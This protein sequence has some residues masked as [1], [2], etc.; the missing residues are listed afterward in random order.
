M[1]NNFTLKVSIS[2]FTM[3]A[4]CQIKVLPSERIKNNHSSLLKT[5]SFAWSQG[6][7]SSYSV[8]NLK[9]LITEGL[10]FLSWNVISSPN[11]DSVQQQIK[12]TLATANSYF[13]K[14][15]VAYEIKY[16]EM[17]L[18][19]DADRSRFCILFDHFPWN[20]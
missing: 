6:F 7:D 20:Y 5:I 2:L 16:K 4:H 10:K 9:N 17:K 19:N 3:H 12:R 18:L 15:L 11:R 1:K 8:M 13:H 14:L